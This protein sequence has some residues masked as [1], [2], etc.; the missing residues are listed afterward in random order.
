M[1]EALKNI[2]YL[3]RRFKLATAFN[4]L[5]LIV[6]FAS[7][8]LMMVQISYQLT[9]NRG[10]DDCERLYRIDTDFLNNNH[11]MSGSVFYPIVNALDSMDEIESYSLMYKVSDDPVYA[12]YFT[13]HFLNKD[14]TEG[15][16]SIMEFPWNGYC[17]EKAISTLTVK[18]L[19]GEIEWKRDDPDPNRRGVIIPKS[20]AKKYFGRV[21]AARD[22]MIY[23]YNDDQITWSVRG[24]YEDFPDNSELPNSIYEV[25]RKEE[26]DVYRYNLSP[27]F[28]CIVKFK[29]VPDD[30]AAL[31]TLLKQELLAMMEREGW[32][33][34][35][36]EAEMEVPFLQSI[37]SSMNIKFTPLRSSYFETSASVSSGKSGFRVMYI[38]LAMSCMLLII[39]AA[40][41]FL[42]FILV[43]SPMRVRGV[44]TRLVLGASRRT[45]RQGIVT[46]CVITSVC[47][48]LIALLLCGILFLSP[49]INQLIDGGL[50]LSQYAMLALLTLVIASAVGIA[51]GLYPARFITSFS[52]AMAL[53]S[54][55]G[56]TLQGHKLRKAIITLQMFISFL[57]VIYLGILLVEEHYIHSS[58]YHYSK[59]KVYMCKVPFDSS[60]SIKR[61]A[62]KELTALPGIEAISFTDGSMGLSDVHPT[63]LVLMGGNDM[64]YDYNTVDSS[65]LTTMGIEVIEGRSFNSCDT[66]SMIINET[67]RRQW[68]GIHVGSKLPSLYSTD[69]LTVV[70]VCRDIRY[71]TTRLHSDKPFAFIIEPGTYRYNLNLRIQDGVSRDETLNDAN[72]ILLKHFPKGATPLE[73]FDKKL[74]ETY[75]TEFRFFHW[76]FILSTVCLVITL[77]GVFCLTLFESEYR[78]KE[79]S[80]RKVAGAKTGEIVN[81]LCRQ[82]IPLI[83]VSF[84]VAA[85]IATFSGWL[86][87]KHFADHASIPWWIFPLA[88]ALVGGIVMATILLQSWRT[89]REN[90]AV[91]IKSE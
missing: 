87:L 40:V 76:I 78:R 50:N 4:L 1:I 33:N 38:V 83:L 52:P 16:D 36:S 57:L 15:K 74:E 80:I 5:G 12:S 10:V 72:R 6:A 43:E 54:N 7:I 77:I 64:S 62:H 48:C 86:T 84:A 17:N 79:I 65:Y 11:L 42:N 45:L 47:A 24:V 41:H 27:N 70:G 67:A 37:T 25:M 88:L 46:E 82:Y 60:D 56:L 2:T 53:K 63:Q 26:K 81:M 61:E 55:F 34:Y 69:S 31:D 21:D 73:S 18:A 89:A 59:D 75:E 68:T 19:S 39:I 49:F 22:T 58:I 51:A 3:A 20:I 9:Y 8:F 66:M 90:P 32:E 29:Q 28:R 35:A 23:I 85:P 91:S 44:N 71:N 30:I 13:Q 14:I